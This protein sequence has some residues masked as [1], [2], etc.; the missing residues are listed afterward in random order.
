MKDWFRRKT[1]TNT[2]EKEFFAKLK[3]ARNDGRVQCLEIQVIELVETRK[4]EL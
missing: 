1:W 4:H 2:D 3:R